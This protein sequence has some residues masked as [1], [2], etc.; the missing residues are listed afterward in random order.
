MSSPSAARTAA[1]EEFVARLVQLREDAGRPSFRTMA[2]RSGAISHATMHDAVRGARMPSWETTVEFA[3][4]CGA[5]PRTLR[6]DWKRMDSVVR[7]AQVRSGPQSVVVP[8]PQ[9]GDP[10]PAAPA[11]IEPAPADPAPDTTASGTAAP[12]APSEP[13]GRRSVWTLVGVALLAAALTLVAS[14]GVSALTRGDGPAPAAAYIAPTAVP[15]AT[16]AGGCPGNGRTTGAHMPRVAGDKGAFVSDVTVPDCS[17]QP[18]GRSIVKTWRLK[19]AG[20]VAWTGRFLQRIN[21]G[22]G[23]RSCR[24]PDRVAI[25]DTVPGATVDVSVTVATPHQSATCF[26]R[27]MQTDS[28][29]NFTFPDQRPYYYSF[30]VR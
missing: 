8:E 20:S 24:A 19:N 16:L 13:A 28:H 22:E 7:A 21:S 17:T 1:I 10:A 3:K 27:W 6:A 23:S 11:D 12:E 14:L 30:F 18:R 4:A 25:P 2:V 29:G 9:V 5:D 15:T 26:A